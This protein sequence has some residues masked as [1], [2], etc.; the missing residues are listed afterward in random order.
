MEPRYRVII[1][2]SRMLGGLETE[3]INKAVSL[4]GFQIAQVVSGGCRGIDKL[5][6]T[7]AKTK[8]IP[9]ERFDADWENLGNVAGPIRNVEMAKYADAAIIIMSL[10]H[11]NKGSW[12]MLKVA[13]RKLL[14][15]RAYF[16]FKEM[17]QKIE[18]LQGT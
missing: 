14:H 5:G 18:E 2:G 17:L 4:S 9:I 13:S 15:V 7:W 16:V 1:S 11:E 12:N 6:E 3:L 8:N 10:A